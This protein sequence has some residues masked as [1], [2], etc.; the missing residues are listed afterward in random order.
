MRWSEMAEK[1]LVDLLAGERIGVV[2]HADLLIDSQTGRVVSL[3]LPLSSSWFSK[4]Q[5]VLEIS[6]SMIRKVGPEMV[7]VEFSRQNYVGRPR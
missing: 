2:G 5:G 1:E 4:K 7:I 6:W 3:L